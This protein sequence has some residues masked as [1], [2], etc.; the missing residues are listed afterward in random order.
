MYKFFGILVLIIIIYLMYSKKIKIKKIPQMLLGKCE[1]GK[2]NYNLNIV[3]PPIYEEDFD[4][5]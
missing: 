2:D 4:D 3:N 1:F 5:E